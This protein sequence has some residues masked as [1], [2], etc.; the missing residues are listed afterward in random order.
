MT[1]EPRGWKSPAAGL[2][3]LLCSAGCDVGTR[4]PTSACA[5]RRPPTH[6]MASAPRA[7]WPGPS[8]HGRSPPAPRTS[9]D[10]S[11]A[12]A[13]VP[14]TPSPCPVWQPQGSA[15]FKLG[16][17]FSAQGPCHLCPATPAP[18]NTVPRYSRGRAP[19]RS[20]APSTPFARARAVRP[21]SLCALRGVSVRPS[22]LRGLLCAQ[23]AVSSALGTLCVPCQ[24]A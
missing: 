18:Q 17:L 13:L 7:L 6:P 4:R 24:R 14:G 23:P 3:S 10:Q 2:C 12:S 8:E 19:S 20:G 16:L 11:S 1:E 22:V 15:E 9:L 5:L 21:C